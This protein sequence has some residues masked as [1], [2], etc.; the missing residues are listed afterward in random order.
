[1]RS[2]FSLVKISHTV[3]AMPFALIGF[4]M[5]AQDGYLGHPFK[6]LLLIV[7]CM[8]FA[9]NAAMAF[10]R[11]VDHSFDAK[12]PRTKTREL[13][14]GVLSFSSVKWFIAI[15]CILFIVCAGFLNYW[16]LILSP[17]AL[18]VI[19][20]YSFTKRFTFLC[21]FVL[22][23]GLALAPVG[24][25]LAAAGQ[26]QWTSIIFGFAILLWVAGFDII[27]ALQDISVD[28]NLG[29]HSIPADFGFQRALFIS[30]LVHVFSALFLCLA[31]WKAERQYSDLQ[32]IHFLGLLVFLVMLFRQ[33]HLISQGDLSKINLAFFTSNGIAS[34]IYGLTWVIDI[35]LF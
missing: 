28:H 7:L 33:H 8:V 26:F 11:L 16:C 2:F 14:A 27:Y 22:G 12:N 4:I 31:A 35:Y 1:M 6:I 30:R 5:A 10:N 24:A 15:N 17:V 25:Y 32:W 13:P 34:V 23:I 19:L 21:H 3:F 9:R 20:G 29:L 18:L